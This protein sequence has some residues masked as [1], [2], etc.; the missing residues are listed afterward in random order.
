MD[1]N[2]TCKKFTEL[3]THELYQI[4]KLRIEVFI[5]E[6]V[7]V[8]QDCDDKDQAC[9]HL[10]GWKK[11]ELVAYARLMPPGLAYVQA[12]IGRIITSATVRRSGAGRRAPGASCGV[13]Q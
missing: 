13:G 9:W 1:I 10:M 7:C 3:D 6:Q 2:Y 4:L 12:S 5:V 8:F 11:E